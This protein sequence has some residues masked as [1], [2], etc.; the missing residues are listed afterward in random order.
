MDDHTLLVLE[1]SGDA[2]RA[3]RASLP[4]FT[5]L[6]GAAGRIEHGLRED[7]AAAG[8]PARV[9]STLADIFGWQ[10]DPAADLRPGDRFSVLYE[11]TWQ[12]GA[13][14]PE[15]GDV[16]AAELV[17]G[18]RALTAVFFEDDDGNGAYYTPAG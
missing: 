2:I 18:G 16:I 8:V 15:T 10:L 3:E 5:E 14:R 1:R 12:T 11:N 13:A 9:V 4:Y 6:K 17:S 7:A